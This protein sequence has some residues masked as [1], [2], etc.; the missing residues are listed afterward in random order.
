VTLPGKYT[1]RAISY[2]NEP[3]QVKHREER[4]QARRETGNV[5]GDVAHKVALANKGSNAKSNRHVE[6]VAKNRGWRAGRKGYSV[7]NEK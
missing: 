4:N 1:K 7:P 3:K 5:K 6:S 2:E